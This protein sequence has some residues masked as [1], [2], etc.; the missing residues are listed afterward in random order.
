MGENNT[1]IYLLNSITAAKIAAGEVVERPLNVVK[2][3]LENSLDAGAEKITLEVNKGGFELIRVTDDGKGILYDDLPLTVERFATSKARSVED[4][5]NISTFGF[6]G[7][8]L[9]ATGAVSRL[10]IRSKREGDKGGELFSEFG[11]IKHILESPISKGTQV[12]VEDLF[13][14]V[15]VRKA[16]QKSER[17][18]L[19]EIAKFIKQF[20]LAN[21]NAEIVFI[22]DGEEIFRVY[23]KSSMLDIAVKVFGESRL[24]YSLSSFQNTR[25]A[26][27]ISNPMIQ[28]KRRDSIFI[29]VNGRVIR[30]QPLIQ[31]VIQGYFRMMPAGS[32]PMAAADIRIEPAALDANIHP[33][34]LE[35]RFR[36]AEALFGQLKI[37]VEDALKKFNTGT[38]PALQSD[39]DSFV[40]RVSFSDNKSAYN[41]PTRP[42]PG[43]DAFTGRNFAPIK[44]S[45]GVKAKAAPAPIIQALGEEKEAEETAAIKVI[46]QLAN[47]YIVCE[48]AEGGLIIIDQHVAHERVLYERYRAG[49][50]QNAS[51][52]LLEPIVLNFSSEEKE[53]LLAKA[54]EFSRFGYFYELF[55]TALRLTGVPAELLKKDAEREFTTLVHEAMENIRSKAADGA[56]VSLSCH[57]AVKAGDP[58]S[59]WEMEKLVSD[60][61]NAENPYTCPH[62]RPIIFEMSREELAKKFHR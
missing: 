62:G 49:T 37:S 1:E 53:Y 59:V 19:S 33:A 27:C 2:E 15:S 41:P 47:M 32:Y 35:V 48:T 43:A 14:N 55:G 10:T 18:S 29:G 46:A 28:R 50:A 56:I 60:L 36:S 34:K 44:R 17:G 9:F 7:E 20:A 12:T 8:A 11:E 51:V 13:A 39:I 16:F 38:F 42:I 61:F 30:D 5:Y 4:V 40:S 52:N 58:L 26:V 24:I 23:P 6:R 54:V 25:I 3:L 45:F 31:A 57:N 21:Y 22:G